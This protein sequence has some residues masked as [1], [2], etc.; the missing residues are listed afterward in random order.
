VQEQPLVS[1]VAMCYNQSKYLLATLESI[2]SQSYRN[3]QLII[4]DDFSSDKSQYLIDKW[5]IE[6]KIQCEFIKHGT[7]LG[8]CKTLN[9][10]LILCKGVFFQ[11]VACDDILLPNKISDQV[12]ILTQEESD[13]VAVFSDAHYIDINGNLLFGT[14]IQDYRK[15]K[16]PENNIFENL[17]SFGNYIPTLT[18]LIR[19]D[20]IRKIGGFDESLF[21][22]DYDLC[23]RLSEL[24]KFRFI[25]T[26]TAQYRKIS[27]ESV[28]IKYQSNIIISE[29][30]IYR[31]WALSDEFGE[32]SLSKMRKI[33]YHFY[34]NNDFI[35][36]KKLVL[37][38]AAL[39]RKKKLLDYFIILKIP[40]KYFKYFSSFFK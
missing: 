39:N 13:V 16:V 18:L 33:I 28:S 8:I 4:T 30:F 10:A 37:N 3:I 31:K 5:I 34:I 15:F 40:H 11:V 6:N 22:E 9:E 24:Y 7:N 38:F 27:S 23:L 12:S 25:N 20:A 14:F 26:I 21:Y 36:A 29:Y 19:I 35:N 32:L 1:V 17:L 2:R